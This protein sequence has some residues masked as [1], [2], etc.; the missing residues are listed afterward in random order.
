MTLLET[1]VTFLFPDQ[2]QIV[3]NNVCEVHAPNCS[4]GVPACP[5]NIDCM[6]F[7]SSS[8]KCTWCPPDDDYPLTYWNMDF[9]IVE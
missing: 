6:V 2:C 9:E 1:F 7:D 4:C 5:Q 3:D 8:M